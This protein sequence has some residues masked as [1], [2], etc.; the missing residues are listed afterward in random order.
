[1]KGK[2]TSRIAGWFNS[3]TIL[4]ASGNDAIKLALAKIGLLELKRISQNLF[5]LKSAIFST[6]ASTW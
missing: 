6:S 3:G 2:I 5:A 1:M 4:P